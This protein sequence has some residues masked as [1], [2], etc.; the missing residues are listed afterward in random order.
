MEIERLAC[1]G[2]NFLPDGGELCHCVMWLSYPVDS[3]DSGL[4]SARTVEPRFLSAV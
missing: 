3:L 1:V 2:K 4:E